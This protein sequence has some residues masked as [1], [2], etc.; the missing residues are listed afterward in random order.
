MWEL[1]WLDWLS[2]F[3]N[4]VDFDPI[5]C[6]TASFTLGS[7][8]TEKGVFPGRFEKEFFLVYNRVEGRA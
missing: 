8:R 6:G 5:T 1:D 3:W 4:R 2:S 7:R